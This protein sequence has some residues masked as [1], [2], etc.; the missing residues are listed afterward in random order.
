VTIPETTGTQFQS[1]VEEAHTRARATLARGRLPRYIP[2]LAKVDA[3]K[4]AVVL[5]TVDGR[6]FGAGDLTQ[7]FTF[8]SVSK[9]FTLAS[10]IS[11]T[12]GGILHQVSSD[13]S[14]DAF[15]SIVR[16]E[17]EHGRPRNPYINAGAILVSERLRGSGAEEKIHSFVEFLARVSGGV[18]PRLDEAVYRS[19]CATGNRNRALAHFMKHHGAI[20][21]PGIAVDTYFRQCSL[22]ID[23]AVLARAALFLANRG[24]DPTTGQRILSADLNRSV[25][26]LMT[27]CG[28]YDEVGRF[29]IEVGLPAKSGVSGAILAVVPGRMTLAVY[30]PKLGPR[31]NSVAGMAALRV[32]SKRLSLSLYG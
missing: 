18:R 32:L 8:Q 7:T 12:G 4:V 25:L 20:E 17:E 22:A 9:V 28:L 15:H 19:E 30:S 6:V 26:A 5:N 14:G 1:A 13:P 23:V 29:A 16:L 2:E 10:V 21:D 24:V 27:T 31:G 11:A 3:S